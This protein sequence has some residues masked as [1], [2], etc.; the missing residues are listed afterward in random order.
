M[1]ICSV[2]SGNKTQEESRSSGLTCKGFGAMNAQLLYVG[3]THETCPAF[4][5]L[6]AESSGTLNSTDFP[7]FP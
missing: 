7:C 3:D 1:V 5:V 4:Q 6:K 2:V